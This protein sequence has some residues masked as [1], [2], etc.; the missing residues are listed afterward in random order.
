MTEQNTAN[1]TTETAGVSFWHTRDDEPVLCTNCAIREMNGS[2]AVQAGLIPAFESMQDAIERFTDL[3]G[4]GPDYFIES[5]T[6]TC[7]ECG[8]TR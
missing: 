4:A 8:E 1:E 3:E 6:G 7:V 5:P 2:F